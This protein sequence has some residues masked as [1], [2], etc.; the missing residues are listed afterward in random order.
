[1]QIVDL[2]SEGIGGG[3]GGDDRRV[4]GRATN[5]A[6]RRRYV[7]LRRH[8]GPMLI[9]RTDEREHEGCPDNAAPH[10][11]RVSFCRRWSVPLYRVITVPR[12]GARSG[13]E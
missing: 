12:S 7:R 13:P 8:L 6:G 3:G 4:R 10:R 2:A 11:A 5:P 1:M 9:T